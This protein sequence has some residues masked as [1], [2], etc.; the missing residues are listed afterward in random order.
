[1]PKNMVTFTLSGEPVDVHELT[2]DVIEDVVMPILDAAVALGGTRPWWQ[3]RADDIRILAAAMR[4]PYGDVRKRIVGLDESRE[5]SAK[6]GELLRIS[7]F[8]MPGEVQAASGSTETSIDSSPDS[9]TTV[10]PASRSGTKS[11]GR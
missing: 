9:S 8:T 1:M 4:E 5:V 7:G 10:S 11:K 6:V 2:W 3:Q